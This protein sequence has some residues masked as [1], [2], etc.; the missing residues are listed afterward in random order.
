MSKKIS[1]KHFIKYSAIVGTSM[2]LANCGVSENTNE[3]KNLSTDTVLKKITTPIQKPSF[4]LVT[5]ENSRY[6]GLRKGIDKYPAA[7]ALCTNTKDVAEAISYA[8]KNNLEIAIKAEVTMWK[9]FRLMMAEWL[10]IFQI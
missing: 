5:K 1:R 4:D 7:I 10:L 8:N 2:L 9:G 3:T 6:N